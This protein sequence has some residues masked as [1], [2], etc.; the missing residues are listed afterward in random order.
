[1]DVEL[2]VVISIIALLIGILL[3]ALGAA[4]RTARDMRCLSNLRQIGIGI[5][6]YSF[7]NE[8]ILPP[9]FLDANVSDAAISGTAWSVLINAYIQGGGR[10]YNDV[11]ADENTEVFLCPSATFDAGNR[12]Y[13]ANRTAMPVLGFDTPE[14]DQMRV[15][16]LDYLRRT[17]ELMLIADAL[18]QRENNVAPNYP[19][20]PGNTY[21]ALDG[22]DDG[23]VQDILPSNNHF[24]KPGD[25]SMD[26]P[27]DPG[28][29]R[30]DQLLGPTTNNIRWRQGIGTPNTGPLFGPSAGQGTPQGTANMVYAD[31][32][33]S[34]NSPSE[35]LR[36]NV[37]VDR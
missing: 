13:A 5:A 23:R 35:V 34:N 14:R 21:E 10:E 9:A 25:P 15:Y 29:N 30:E 6:G 12:H 8:T 16:R 4:R 19:V 17:T 18:Q 28:P 3:P 2:L 7:D 11:N 37:L 32:H 27:I 26:E 1:M 24:F 22:L 31:G 36:R 20:Q 33:A